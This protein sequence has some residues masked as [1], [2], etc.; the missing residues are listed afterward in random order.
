MAA[1]GGRDTRVK[2]GREGTRRDARARGRAQ[3]NNG[4]PYPPSPLTRALCLFVP[5]SSSLSLSLSLP[6]PLSPSSLPSPSPSLLLLSDPHP[7]A[8]LPSSSLVRLPT[9]LLPTYLT[10]ITVYLLSLVSSTLRPISHL[11]MTRCW[12]IAKRERRAAKKAERPL[13]SS[14]FRGLR[15]RVTST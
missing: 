11:E 9:Y 6:L 10:T 14:C 12:Q 3:L 8:L 4:L 15:A 2:L 5:S 1:R 13:L 7:H